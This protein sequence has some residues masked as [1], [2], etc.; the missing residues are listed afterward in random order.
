MALPAAV[1]RALRASGHR[2]AKG[3]VFDT[4]IIAGVQAVKRTAE[5]IPFCHPLPIEDCSIAI[6]PGAAISCGFAAAS[7]RITRPASKWKRSP[8]PQ[9]RR[10]PS[11]TCARRSRTTSASWTCAC[12]TSRVADA[13]WD[14]R[15]ERDSEWTGADRAVAAGE[16]KRDKAALEYAGQAAAGS[17]RW[18]CSSRWWRAP[19]FRC[20]P[21]N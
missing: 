8:A 11:T 20:G 14:G 2:S 1:A 21:I 7:R 9:S 16:C 19:S 6:T 17:A 18:R 3:P 15:D 5:I 12:S 13:A 10:S 4:A